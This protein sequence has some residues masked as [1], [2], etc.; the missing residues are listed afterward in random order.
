MTN[1]ISRIGRFQIIEIEKPIFETETYSR[2]RVNRDYFT[3][4]CKYNNYRVVVRVPRGE[5]IYIPNLMKQFKKV[6]EV[7][8]RPDE[9]MKL[10]ELDIPHSQKRPDE[11]FEVM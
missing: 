11:Y 4:A 5:A 6:E 10:Y 3:Q 7:F 1:H 9:P 8:L 2:V